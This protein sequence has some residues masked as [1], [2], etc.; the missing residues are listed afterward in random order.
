MLKEYYEKFKNNEK[1]QQM[2]WK[3]DCTWRKGKQWASEHREE[4]I[5]LATVVVTGA[6]S[7]TKLAVRDNNR[8]KAEQYKDL[9]WY[10]PS[11][12]KYLTLK[13]KAT[14][15]EILEVDRRHKNGESITSILDDMRL[16]K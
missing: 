3:A 5:G 8:R 12:G 2:K 4:A 15:K 7:L 13:R 9:H 1:V 14:A 10:D 6:V 16:I 11:L